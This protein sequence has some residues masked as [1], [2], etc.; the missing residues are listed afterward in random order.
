MRGLAQTCAPLP[1]AIGGSGRGR[2][3]CGTCR[4]DL[5]EQYRAVGAQDLVLT[6]QVQQA[7]D[8]QRYLDDLGATS[9]VAC[10][11][12]ASAE[13][14]HDRILARTR[15]GGPMLAGDALV[16]LTA[17]DAEIVLHD[18]LT[19][20]GRL[21]LV[22]FADITLDTAGMSP[23]AVTQSVRTAFDRLSDAAPAAFTADPT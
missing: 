15:G 10:R 7:A 18:A 22:T 2:H 4:S 19:Q 1:T 17:E 12:H 3:W 23:E 9:L 21:E 11:L 6:G 16:G 14:L 5:W 13:A 8:V 20:Q